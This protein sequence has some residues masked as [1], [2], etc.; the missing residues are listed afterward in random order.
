MLAKID[1]GNLNQDHS[2]RGGTVGQGPVTGNWKRK[3][4]K[5]FYKPLPKIGQIGSCREGNRTEN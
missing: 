2:P 3:K 5:N 1:K 4:K